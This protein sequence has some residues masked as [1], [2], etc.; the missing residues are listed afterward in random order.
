MAQAWIQDAVLKLKGGT[1][2]QLELVDDGAA[3]TRLLPME[4]HDYSDA[5]D[6]FGA[7]SCLL[8]TRPSTQLLAK[9]AP[10]EPEVSPKPR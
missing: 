1:A 3:G 7:K 8:V 9:A 2:S 6:E 4:R 5:T 10:Q